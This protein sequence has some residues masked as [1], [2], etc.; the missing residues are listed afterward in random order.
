MFCFFYILLA[1]AN[2]G[3]LNKSFFNLD[4]LKPAPPPWSLDFTSSYLK[5]KQH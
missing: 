3:L 1:T 4:Y 2:D 5:L